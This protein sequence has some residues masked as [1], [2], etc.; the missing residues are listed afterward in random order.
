MSTDYSARLEQGRHPH[1]SE[2]VLEAVDGALRL[3]DLERGYLFELARSCAQ[4]PPPSSHL[5]P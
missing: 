3:D 2:T 5:E 1:V 4:I